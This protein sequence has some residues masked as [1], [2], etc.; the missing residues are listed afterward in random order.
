MFGTRGM[1]SAIRSLARWLRDLAPRRVMSV[2]TMEK[3]AILRTAYYEE[4]LTYSEILPNGLMQT[5]VIS[6][7]VTTWDTTVSL[8][9]APKPPMIQLWGETIH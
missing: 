3:T 5:M 4:L 2:N 8:T 1:K 6:A 9:G 7:P